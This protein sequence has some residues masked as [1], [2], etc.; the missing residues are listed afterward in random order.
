MPSESCL[1]HAKPREHVRPY[2]MDDYVTLFRLYSPAVATVITVFFMAMARVAPIVALVPFLAARQMPGPVKVMFAIMLTLVLLPKLVL[3]SGTHLRL[4]PELA[5]Y[6][7]KEIFIGLCMAIIASIPF[8]VANSAGILIDHQR[9][10]DSLMANDPTMETQA[11]PAGILYN[12]VLL[13]L[14]FQLDGPFFFFDALLTSFDVLPVD[15]FP[16]IA[17]FTAKPDSPFWGVW[18]GLIGYVLRMSVQLAGP[19][20]VAMLMTDMFLGIAN[21]LAPQVQISFLGMALKAWVGIA[22]MFVAWAFILKI[23]G[24]ESITWMQ[25]LKHLIESIY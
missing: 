2:S 1:K 6:L 7:I 12:A 15:K 18:V 5:P 16:S 14:F 13:V 17:F 21:R 3:M 23:M 11:S 24:R 20:L 19:S 22:A 25:G 8:H 9:G 4:S 10:A